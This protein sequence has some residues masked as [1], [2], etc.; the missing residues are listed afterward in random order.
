LKIHF[1]DEAAQDA[2]GLIREWFSMITEE[3]LA[4]NHGPLIII[5]S[6]YFRLIFTL[7]H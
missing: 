2:G 7:P 4:K 1:I 3:L 6:Y 5:L